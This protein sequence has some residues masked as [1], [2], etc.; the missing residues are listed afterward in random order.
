MYNKLAEYYDRLYLK[1]DY[2]KEC[3]FLKNV[4][5]HCKINPKTILDVGCGTGTH[6]SNLS[7]MGYS[8][9]GV[10][11]SPEMIAIAKAKYPNGSFDVVDIRE[12]NDVSKFDV[13]ISMF[14]TMTYLTTPLQFNIALESIHQALKPKGLFIFDG[15]N[16]FA[17]NRIKPPNGRMIEIEK[18]VFKYTEM[19]PSGRYIASSK[20]MLLDVPNNIVIKN[21]CELLLFTKDMLDEMLDMNGFKLVHYWKVFTP[22][23]SPSIDD[24]KVSVVARKK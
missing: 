12:M 7:D 17:V 10:D 3:N 19:Y 5:R 16:A 8:V 9:H 15:W 4:F 21:K 2:K 18:D 14:C 20:F 22:G 11:I 13:V 24:W 1:K 23:M 6:C